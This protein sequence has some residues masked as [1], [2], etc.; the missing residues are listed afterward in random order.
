MIY[1]EEL[2][3]RKQ[4]NSATS[5][6]RRAEEHPSDV[7]LLDVHMPDVDGLATLQAMSADGRPQ[8]VPEPTS[9]SE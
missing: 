9:S 8:S 2:D 7:L 3:E 6:G 1:A 5:L 4:A